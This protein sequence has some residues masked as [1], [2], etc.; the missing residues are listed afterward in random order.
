MKAAASVYYQNNGGREKV[1][2]YRA[3]NPEWYRKVKKRAQ[4]KKK[5]RNRTDPIFREKLLEQRK[6][7]SR[8][9]FKTV[10]LSRARARAS[11]LGIEFTLT[12][13]DINIP[14]VC[15]ILLA[16]FSFGTK[17]NYHFTPSL[18]RIDPS[19][20]YTKENTK[21]ICSLANTMKNCATK[22]QLITFCTTIP[23]YLE[24]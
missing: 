23:T 21:V 2:A 1:K 24:I 6:A 3:A 14:D 17:E 5:I 16:P 9:N 12:K 11:I 18:D 22:E 20:G 4:E 7:N 8:K 10:M 13:E 15:P 19:K